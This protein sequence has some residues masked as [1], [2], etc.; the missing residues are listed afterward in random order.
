MEIPEAAQI[1]SQHLRQR[2]SSACRVTTGVV[3]DLADSDDDRV[4]PV[5]VAPDIHERR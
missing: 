1:R 4:V 3:D 5:A 2:A